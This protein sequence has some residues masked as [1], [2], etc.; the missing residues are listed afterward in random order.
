[1]NFEILSTDVLIIG[2]GGAG[3]RAAIEA[4]KYGAHVTLVSK[5]K[6]GYL[7]S[8]ALAAGLTTYSTAE[9]NEELFHLVVTEG[10]F[11]L[12]QRLV[13]VFVQDVEWRI[14]ELR[15]FGVTLQ[16]LEREKVPGYNP[17]NPVPLFLVARTK[18]TRNLGLTQPLR[19]TAEG[20]GVKI[21]DDVQVTKLLVNGKTVVG[22]TA[23]EV[24][25]DKL[26]V[27]LAKSTIL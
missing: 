8:T 2:G 11:L 26:L 10:G 1:M 23:L 18:E 6:A 3:L 21:L 13:E 22:A 19:A 25:G 24:Q 27:V 15:N 17:R 7:N 20:L 16:F 5:I 14:L 9:L 4:R 12:N